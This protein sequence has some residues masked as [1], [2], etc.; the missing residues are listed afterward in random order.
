MLICHV[1]EINSAGAGAFLPALFHSSVNC[2]TSPGQYISGLSLLYFL[3]DVPCNWIPPVSYVIMRLWGNMHW[4]NYQSRKHA[5]PP[6]S[7]S[8]WTL[9]TLTVGLVILC[10][11]SFVWSWNCWRNFQVCA[12][13]FCL[14][15]R[16]STAVSSIKI[17]VRGNNLGLF[18]CMVLDDTSTPPPPTPPPTNPQS[19]AHTMQVIGIL[20]MWLLILIV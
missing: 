11:L 5:A 4:L 10:Y 12:N 8:S 13:I 18:W 1:M 15:F 16:I 9:N 7:T 6:R 19:H 3:G 17:R 2:G 20:K 14:I